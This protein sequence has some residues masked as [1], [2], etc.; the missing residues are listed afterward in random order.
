MTAPP[1][2]EASELTA[3]WYRLR[4]SFL[5]K[6]GKMEKKERN[7]RVMMPHPTASRGAK[8]I[9][10]RHQKQHTD[11]KNRYVYYHASKKRHPRAHTH[12]A[13]AVF[14]FFFFFF[15]FSLMDKHLL[16]KTTSKR[17]N[18]ANSGLHAIIRKEKTEG[19]H[20]FARGILSWVGLVVLTRGASLKKSIPQKKN[21]FT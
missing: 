13:S 7:A 12:T 19:I 3:K 10:T 4:N 20:T 21:W 5:H 14:C 1:R 11:K 16:I 17:K 15:F 18:G 2:W 6:P 8:N 9:S